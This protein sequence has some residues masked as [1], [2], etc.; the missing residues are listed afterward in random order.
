MLLV[1][2]LGLGLLGFLEPCSI[3]SS[4][5]FLRTLEG[6]AQPAR[7]R[8]VVTFTLVRALSL[9]MLGVLAALMGTVFVSLQ[10]AFWV[11]LGAGYAG[12]GLVYLLGLE[13]VLQ[14]TLGPSLRRREAVS[15]SAGLGLLFGLNLPACAAPILAAVFAATL[16][17][18]TLAQ[19]FLALAVFGV[20]LSFPLLVLIA[21][22]RGAEVL[23]RL[24]AMAHRVPRGTG[25]VFLVLG[26]WAVYSGL[27]P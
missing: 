8:A 22:P 6:R 17:A 23:E 2:P 1:L 25:A 13:G 19:G 16:G 4:A 10:R 7:W 27:A 12:L 26:V 18:G 15:T 24:T 5:I 14:G 3:G 21:W 20:A 9:G 11:A